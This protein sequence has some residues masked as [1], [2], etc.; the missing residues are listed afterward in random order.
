[1]FVAFVVRLV[2][3][4][5]LLG[6][7]SRI[8]QALWASHGLDGIPDLQPFHDRGVVALALAPLA[9]ALIGFGRF[10]RLALFLAF[11][12]AGAALTAPFALS[13]LVGS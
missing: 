10:G 4:A 8:A 6:V 9:F 12:L 5:L 13:H 11:A 1:M 7:T 3:Y 2:L